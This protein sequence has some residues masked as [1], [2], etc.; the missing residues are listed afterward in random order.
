MLNSR[1]FEPKT[2]FFYS[3]VKGLIKPLLWCLPCS[4]NEPNRR[5]WTTVFCRVRHVYARRSKNGHQLR[6]ASVDRLP[7]QSRF[8]YLHAGVGSCT[9]QLAHCYDERH[10]SANSGKLTSDAKRGNFQLFLLLHYMRFILVTKMV[11][12]EHIPVAQKNNCFFQIPTSLKPKFTRRSR[13]NTRFTLK[14]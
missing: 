14:V 3:R 9:D 1:R 5:F 10:L 11:R 4:A 2:L 12:G 7:V 6:S 13:P 8:W